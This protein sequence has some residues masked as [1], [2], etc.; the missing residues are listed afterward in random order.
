MCGEMGNKTC[1]GTISCFPL[2]QAAYKLLPSGHHAGGHSKQRNY[3]WQVTRCQL[4]HFDGT[5]C[6]TSATLSVL[7]LRLF[8]YLSSGSPHRVPCIRSGRMCKG[9]QGW[10]SC[11]EGPHK[12]C[13]EGPHEVPR[14][15]SQGA[16]KG[17]TS[18]V[19]RWG[20]H[21]SVMVCVL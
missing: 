14:R 18:C 15:A 7:S 10:V 4:D 5:L 19:T 20:E 12:V 13:H 17:L 6:E 21:A 16:T 8:A 11:H 2:D 1:V 3:S 9:V